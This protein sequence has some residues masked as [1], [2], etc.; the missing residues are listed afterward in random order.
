MQRKLRRAFVP[1][2]SK[3][4]LHK[5]PAAQNTLIKQLVILQSRIEGLADAATTLRQFDWRGT[6]NSIGKELQIAPRCGLFA[7]SEQHQQIGRINQFRPFPPK[8]LAVSAPSVL[9]KFVKIF[10]HTGTQGV[11]MDVAHQFKQIGF[12]VAYNRFITVLKKV[13]ERRCRKLNETA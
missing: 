10:H 1:T 7:V 8:Q 3:N 2:R 6:A 12:F 5:I 13:P 4:L 11:E 9:G